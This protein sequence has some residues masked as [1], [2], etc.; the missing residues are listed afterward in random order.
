MVVSVAACVCDPV[1]LA[2]AGV[3][4]AGRMGSLG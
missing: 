3:T 1:D 4:G 2:H